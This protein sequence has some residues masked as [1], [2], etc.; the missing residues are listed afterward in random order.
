MSCE[1]RSSG[2]D[3]I[4]ATIMSANSKDS[5]DLV[6]VRTVDAEEL[7]SVTWSVVDISDNMLPKEIVN[8]G[9]LMLNG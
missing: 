2:K 9:H 8:V 5:P 6:E 1:T 3:L 4:A 7:L